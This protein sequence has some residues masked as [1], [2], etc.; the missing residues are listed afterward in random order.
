M[1]QATG[2]VRPYETQ[3]TEE[4]GRT[5]EHRRAILSSAE[6]AKYL[7]LAGKFL[8]TNGSGRNVVS[9][10]SSKHFKSS[11]TKTAA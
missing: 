9:I 7:L 10:D 3:S 8:S 1:N 5:A 4:K 2:A 6:Q 11:K